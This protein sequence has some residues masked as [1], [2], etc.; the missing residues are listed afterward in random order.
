[1]STVSL[2]A[3]S[4]T[5]G[6]PD[7]ARIARH[8]SMPFI[9]GSIRSSSTTSGRSSRTAGNARVPSAT[10]AVSNPS[11][12]STM[13]SISASAGSSSTT[14]TRDF[15]GQSIPLA[16]HRPRVGPA[17]RPSGRSA[18]SP[19]ASAAGSAAAVEPVHGASQELAASCA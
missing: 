8:T 18:G 3:V 17:G 6:T 1:M 19:A 13:V 7:S 2:L 9:P 12:R 11:P 14:R 16:G 4:I 10:T 15:M 5:I